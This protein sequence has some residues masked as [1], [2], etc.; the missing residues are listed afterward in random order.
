[1]LLGESAAPHFRHEIGKRE[2][3]E[4]ILNLA[5]LCVTLAALW[6]WRF[7]WAASRRNPQH[8]IR[9]EACAIVCLLALLFPVISLSDDLHPEIAVVDSASAKR[10][11]LA[12]ASGA[13]NAHEGKVPRVHSMVALLPDLPGKPGFVSERFPSVSLVQTFPVS[14]EGRSG[15]S[16]PSL[17]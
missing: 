2:M 15:R 6:V 9:Q 1:M 5:W 17:L 8:N 12:A 16:P 7:R 11:C 4:T 10:H 3:M 13:H 14:A